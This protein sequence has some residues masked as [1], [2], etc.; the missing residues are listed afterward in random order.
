M[1][2]FERLGDHATNISEMAAELHDKGL[3]FSDKALHDLK[4]LRELIDRILDLAYQAFSKR[5]GEAAASIEP[6]EEVVDDM[7]NV[8]KEGH[9][10]RLRAG[11]CNIDAGTCFL[12]LLSDIERISDLCSNV[13][14]ETIARINPE[15]EFQSH[16]YMSSLHSGSSERFNREYHA[17]HDEFFAK[18]SAE[19]EPSEE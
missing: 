17:A 4:V 9:I 5:D 10:A 3:Q 13:G 18:L 2:E 8:L 14:V 16:D 1:T 12:N 11:E 15:L 6:L 19:A 7:T